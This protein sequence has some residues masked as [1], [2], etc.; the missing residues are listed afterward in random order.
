MEELNHKG[1]TDVFRHRRVI[2]FQEFRLGLRDWNLWETKFENLF[3]HEISEC[4]DHYQLIWN[5]RPLITC[6]SG[7]VGAGT[8]HVRHGDLI[9][10]IPGCRLPVL[11][12]PK[13]H[14]YRIIGLAFVDGMMLGEG[15]DALDSGQYIMEDLQIC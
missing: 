11:L 9:Y 5:V 14:H 15:M 12:R 1:W 13:D 10:V 3:P 2:L 7:R 6:E 4:P 8:M